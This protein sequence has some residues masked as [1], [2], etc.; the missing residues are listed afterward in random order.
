LRRPSD[1]AVPLAMSIGLITR[2]ESALVS[3]F[4]FLRFIWSRVV[5]AEAA[6][7]NSDEE[8]IVMP[9]GVRAVTNGG[10]GFW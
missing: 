4:T 5:S 6:E 1:R 9:V 3:P 8:R 7:C 2:W 10:A